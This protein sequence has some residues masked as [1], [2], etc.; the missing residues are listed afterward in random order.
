LL[1]A[2]A[3]GKQFLI[4][5]GF[6]KISGSVVDSYGERGGFG[7]Y[8]H[9]HLNIDVIIP[10]GELVGKSMSELVNLT[11]DFNICKCWWSTR[12]GFVYEQDCMEDVALKT[13]TLCKS[14]YVNLKKSFLCHYPRL[15]KKFPDH[16]FKLHKDYDYKTEDA[17]CLLSMM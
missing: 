16:T 10:Q 13:V 4:H 17:K 9:D 5:H 3:A 8:K 7:V 6:R 1:N 2:P 15:K 12:H 14:K 11:Y